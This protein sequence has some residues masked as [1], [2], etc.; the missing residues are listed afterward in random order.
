VFFLFVEHLLAYGNSAR[1]V[2]EN[3]QLLSVRDMFILYAKFSSDDKIL[4]RER[5]DKQTDGQT[6]LA[7][8]AL[9]QRRRYF[10]VR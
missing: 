4:R 9:W 10:N 8:V 6:D 1:P 7:F 2:S 3:S 5:R